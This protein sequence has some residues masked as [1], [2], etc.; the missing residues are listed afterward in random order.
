VF[1]IDNY[2]II[3]IVTIYSQAG[4]RTTTSNIEAIVRLIK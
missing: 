3:H 1:W 4:Y 2:W